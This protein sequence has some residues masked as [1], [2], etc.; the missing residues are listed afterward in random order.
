MGNKE[1]KILLIRKDVKQADIARKLK[2][3]KTAIHNVIKGIS[4]S[5]RIKQA[6]AEILGV[7]VADLW[8]DHNRKAA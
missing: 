2:V 3:S 7:N 1:I 5:K 6:I 4:T 8:T